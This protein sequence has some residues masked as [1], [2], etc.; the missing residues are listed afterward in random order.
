MVLRKCQQLYKESTIQYIRK[1][2]IRNKSRNYNEKPTY[3]RYDNAYGCNTY[4]T[5]CALRARN[6][7]GLSYSQLNVMCH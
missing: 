3:H 1:M 4:L 2:K 7:D 5:T 6:G